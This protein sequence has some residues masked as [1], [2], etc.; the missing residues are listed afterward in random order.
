MMSGK[1]RRVAIVG[2]GLAGLAAAV[3][4]AEL[5]R[6][7][8]TCGKTDGSSLEIHLFESGK[9]LGGR[10]GSVFLREENVLLDGAQHIT[11]NCCTEMMDFLRKTDLI[12]FWK[13]EKCM[14][15]CVREPENGTSPLRFYPFRNAEWLP[16]PFQLAPALCGMG[17]LTVGERIQLPILLRKIQKKCP[18]PGLP[19]RAWLEELGCSD[20]LMTQF[21]EPV[22]LSAFSE[23]LES[24]SARLAQTVLRRMFGPRNAWH[25]WRPTRPLREIFD[26][27]F[28][29]I[30]EKLGIHIHRQTP[31]TRVLP[32]GV[33]FRNYEMTGT[34]TEQDFPADV[35]IL[36]VPWFRVGKIYPELETHG[37]LRTEIFEPRSIAAVHFWTEKPLFRQEHLVFPSETIQWIFRPE[38][39]SLSELGVYHQVLISDANRMVSPQNTALE[40]VVRAELQMLFPSAKVKHFRVTRMPNA[41]FSP[42]PWME[43]ARPT[44]LTPYP[45]VFLAGDWTAT[46]LPATMES[47]IVSGNAAARET[48]YFLTDSA[49]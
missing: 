7:K 46:D 1:K 26:A 44:A 33:R 30:L 35:V 9:H 36:A 4:L 41:V 43:H 8:S 3:R 2:G 27:E 20:R 31:I 48:I 19:L 29:P 13:E 21:F 24:V 25:F 12:R 42:N 39:G 45:N 11:M 16:T 38:F 28:T 10:A 14:T 22:T 6:E 32:E 47:A 17:F 49:K 5:V 37:L 15:F 40:R 34:A 23:Q 18:A